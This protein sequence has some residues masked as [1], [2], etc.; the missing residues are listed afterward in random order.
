MNYLY[1]LILFFSVMVPFACSFHGKI[2]FHYQFKAAFLSI[3]TVA[4]PFVWW[5]MYF[6][7]LSVWGFNPSYVLGISLYNLPLEEI[8]FF[9]CI[10]FCCLFTYHSLNLMM[11]S[12]GPKQSAAFISILSGTVLFLTGLFYLQRSYTLWSFTTAGLSLIVLG[13]KRPFYMNKFWVAYLVLLLPF[14]IVNGI[15]TGT[16]PDNPVVWYNNAEN[17]QLRILTIPVEDFAYGM[18]L[19]L[20][21][22]VLFE[23]FSKKRNLGR[24][25]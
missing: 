23:A 10:P 12:G 8:L 3:L 19:I 25:I 6:T 16:G 15:L 22:I 11:K 14:F 4:L 2:N 13:I 5:D 17:L 18:T 1:L 9:I 7:A 24:K 20:W 21:N